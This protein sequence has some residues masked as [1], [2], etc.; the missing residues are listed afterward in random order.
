MNY[1]QIPQSEFPGQAMVVELY[2]T[3]GVRGVELGSCAFSK[4]DPITGE[5]TY[6]ELDLV[7]LSIS[8]RVY[9]NRHMDVVV[10]SLADVYERRDAMKGLR[11]TYEGPI[12][13]LRHF[14]AKFELL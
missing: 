10:N 12:L 6:P 4:R 2:K 1:P 3:G 8:R 14:T 13:S 9:T 5:I 11:I 7:R